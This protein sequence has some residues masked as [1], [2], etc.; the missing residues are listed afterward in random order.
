MSN[1]LIGGW[2]IS[3]IF[4]TF[5]GQFLTPTWDGQDTTG[6]AYT[7]SGRATVT[8]RPDILQNPNLPDGQQ[9]VNHWFDTSAFAPPQLGQFGTSAKGVIIGPGVNNW[10]AGIHK[11]FAF[12]NEG[13]LRL[14]VELTATNVFNHPNWSNPKT[15]ISS[16]ETLGVIFGVGGV[17]GRSMGDQ[18]GPR[19]LR[20]GVRVEW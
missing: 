20:T 16:P 8:R 14:R 3:G 2:E 17:N 11:N 15:D 5:S 9:S 18:P 10:D 19:T 13:A 12:R 7:N 1:L 6:I 4:S